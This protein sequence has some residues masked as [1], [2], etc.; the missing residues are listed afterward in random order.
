MEI[1]GVNV[2]GFIKGEFGLG[3]GVRSTIRALE[4]QRVNVALNNLEIESPHRQKDKSFTNI[5]EKNPFPVNI[6]QINGDYIR[7]VEENFSSDYFKNRYNIAYWVWESPEIPQH[8]QSKLF[9]FNE[10]WTPSSFCSE[11]FAPVSPVPVLT[12]PHPINVPDSTIT[13]KELK[14]LSDKFIFLFIFDF[15]SNCERKNPR[16]AIKAFKQA[17]GTDE[18]VLLFL[19]ST[20]AEI[21]EGEFNKLKAEAGNASNIKI[22]NGFW[23]RQYLTGLMRNCDCYVS[24]HRAE[25][26]GLTVAEAMFCGKPVIATDYSA[27][28]EFM[29]VNNSFPVRYTLKVMEKDFYQYKKG[30]KW[31]EP[32]ISH[33]ADLMRQMFESPEQAKQIGDNAAEY[34]KSHFGLEII[35]QKMRKRLE[36]I[37]FLTDNFND[38]TQTLDKLSPSVKT[39]VALRNQIELSANLENRIKL[40]EES[41]FW[42][43]RNQWFKL[44]DLLK[45]R[46]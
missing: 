46:K 30:G 35:G 17:F 19:K 3:E 24:P 11:A 14:L 40:M 36:F 44:K 26:F 9:L 41:K 34:I 5:T 13:R 23:D 16:A 20:N 33:I 37:G 7:N 8:W 6:V 22:V 27:T 25:G 39:Q 38:I 2:C 42:K 4:T 15:A 12:I 45:G 43:I 1:E 21:A 32:D 28:S 18:R 31:A 29:N 10:I